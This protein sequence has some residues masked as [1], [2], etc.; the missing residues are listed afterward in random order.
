MV[1]KYR[2]LL[3][4]RREEEILSFD[5]HESLLELINILKSIVEW[6]VCSLHLTL[7]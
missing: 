6:L 2:R 4:E 1:T 7:V 5:V 3:D